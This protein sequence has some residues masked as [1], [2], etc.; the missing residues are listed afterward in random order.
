ME[1]VAVVIPNYNGKEYLDDCLVSLEKQTYRDFKVLVVDNASQDGS[2]EYI[3]ANYPDV[4]VLELGSNTGFAN[5]VN[6][7]IRNTDSKYVFLLRIAVFVCS[8]RKLRLAFSTNSLY[9]CVINKVTKR[10]LV[11]LSSGTIIN[12]AL[13][14][15]S[16]FTI[17]KSFSLVKD[18]KPSSASCC[19]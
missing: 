6:E 16:I 14:S 13:G 8:L 4:E 9:I 17:S 1:S 10:C 5:A 11:N 12:T 18:I 2:V 15:S 7:G 3:R 19:I